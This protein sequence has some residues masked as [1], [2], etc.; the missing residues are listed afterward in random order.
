MRQQKIIDR[1]ERMR[2]T[3]IRQ[4]LTISELAAKAGLTPSTIQHMDDPD[5]NPMLRTLA[6]LDEALFGQ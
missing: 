1:V 4:K 3:R 6:K 2:K 5:W